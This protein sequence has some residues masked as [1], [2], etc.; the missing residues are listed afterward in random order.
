MNPYLRQLITEEYQHMRRVIDAGQEVLTEIRHEWTEPVDR[1]HAAWK[2]YSEA[3]IAA[4]ER[5]C[6]QGR[7]GL[8][9]QPMDVLPFSL[10]TVEI[11][12][13]VVRA[14]LRALLP[15]LTHHQLDLK[16]MACSQADFMKFLAWDWTNSFKPYVAETWDCDD[17]GFYL[18]ARCRQFGLNAVGYVIDYSAGHA[19]N[20][21]VF[22]DCSASIWEP[23]NDKVCQPGTGIYLAQRGLVIL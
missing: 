22:R 19:Y 10:Q 21:C 1:E 8:K 2:R 23:Q 3:L 14:A 17:F 12:A 16:V 11:D 4:N 7:P 6:L 5:A 15:N 18:A 20:V 9:V 13:S